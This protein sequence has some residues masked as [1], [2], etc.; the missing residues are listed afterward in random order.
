V[1]GT[2]RTVLLFV[3]GLPLAIAAA[4]AIFCLWLPLAPLWAALLLCGSTSESFTNFVAMNLRIMAY[5]YIGPPAVVAAVVSVFVCFALALPLLPIVIGIFS[6]SFFHNR[7]SHDG[8]SYFNATSCIISLIRLWFLML[9]II[10]YSGPVVAIITAAAAC[11]VLVQ[12]LALP[13][14]FLLYRDLG[15]WQFLKDEL[16]SLFELFVHIIGTLPSIAIAIATFPLAS[17]LLAIYYFD[18][19]VMQTHAFDVHARAFAL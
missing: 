1:W 18:N 9:C 3:V 16:R 2:F 10:V 7:R 12:M 14:T 4:S 17:S 15:S 19:M 8:A 5:I 11:V 13:R 6:F